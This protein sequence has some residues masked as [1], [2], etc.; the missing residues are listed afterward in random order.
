MADKDYARLHQEF[1]SDSL[2]HWLHRFHVDS[3]SALWTGDPAV[4]VTHIHAS[5]D[6]VFRP[7]G[8]LFQLCKHPVTQWPTWLNY[9]TEIN[10]SISLLRCRKDTLLYM[11]KWGYDVGVLRGCGDC[12]GGHG[13]GEWATCYYFWLLSKA[14]KPFFL[15][16]GTDL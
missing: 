16:R 13:E 5:R 11:S 6:E 1:A 10:N 3:P 4:S 12:G 8:G 15:I 9:L 2:T 7:G 14:A